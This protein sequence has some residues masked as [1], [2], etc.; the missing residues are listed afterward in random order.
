[1]TC[2]FRDAA[3][4][5]EM[6]NLLIT[7]TRQRGNEEQHFIKRLEQGVESFQMNLLQWWKLTPVIIQDV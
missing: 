5:L 7:A 3:L 1:V 6:Q 4:L 2:G